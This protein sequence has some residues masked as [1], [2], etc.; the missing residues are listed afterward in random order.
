MRLTWPDMVKNYCFRV[1]NH[2]QVSYDKIFRIKNCVLILL[3]SDATST[4]YGDIA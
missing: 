1:Y 3:Y 2:Q 4:S